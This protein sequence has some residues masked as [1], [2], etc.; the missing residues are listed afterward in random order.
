MVEPV[1]QPYF[2]QEEPGF[3]QGI[4]FFHPGNVRGEHH[5][6]Q[7]GKILQQV[8]KLKN[9]TNPPAAVH[10]KGGLGKAGYFGV[11]NHDGPGIGAIQPS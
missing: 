5:I 11:P 8:V 4:L 9:K 2:L 1:F 3:F 7:G 10:T 6:F